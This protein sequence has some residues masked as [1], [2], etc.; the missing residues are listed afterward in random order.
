[1]TFIYVIRRHIEYYL[2]W[3][4]YEVFENLRAVALRISRIVNVHAV[5]IR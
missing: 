3:D 4:T 2:I 5:A 1:L